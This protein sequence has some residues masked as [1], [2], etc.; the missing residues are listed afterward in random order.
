MEREAAELMGARSRES[1]L[2]KLGDAAVEL[3]RAMAIAK[4]IAFSVLFLVFLVPGAYLVGKKHK[5]QTKTAGRIVPANSSESPKS[6]PICTK[7]TK[8]ERAQT[9]AA[10]GTPGPAT[11][12]TTAYFDCHFGVEYDV[13]GEK[14]HHE[15]STDGPTEYVVHDSVGLY[16][17]P[18]TPQSVSLVKDA[19]ATRVLG[20]VLL[21]CAALM[22]ACAAWF[23][24]KAF[25]AEKS[26][27][28]AGL[29]GAYDG[30]TIA[31]AV[32]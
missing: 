25:L 10:G 28:A 1:G 9:S 23:M 13:D 2:G 32:L 20:A 29:F 22:G 17:Y 4:A 12:V 18:S 24:G 21:G 3:G 26:K 27:T 16:Y 19:D 31:E 11:E 7:R 30:A 8:R 6:S 14:L 15:F 5:S